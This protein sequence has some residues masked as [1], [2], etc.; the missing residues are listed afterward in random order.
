MLNYKL[1]LLCVLFITSLLG[2]TN[3][4]VSLQ[5]LWKHQFEFAG[6]YMAK[7]KGFYN[8]HKIDV[9]FKE[10]EVGT[11]ITKDVLNG[12]TTFGIGYPNIILEKSNGA[13]ITLLNA[14]FQS[15]PHALVTL[16]SSDIK[17]INDFKN[18]SIMVEND[19][20][21]TA[22]LL[23]MLY[24][25]KIKLEDM[26]TI[27][28][29][30]NIDDLVNHKVDIFSAYISNEVYKLD[31]NN[32]KYNIWNPKDYGFDF[33]NDLLFTSTKTVK[34][35]KELVDN[36]INASIRG[37]LYAFDNIDET[38]NL[39]FTKYNT[40]N[41]TKEALK[42]EAE[43]LKELAF[44][45]NSEFGSIDTNKI[46]RIYD[47]YNLMGLTKNK[48]DLEHFIYK[49]NNK[50]INL[51]DEEKLWIKR[52]TVKIGIS[53]W[54]PITYYNKENNKF[55][56]VGFDMV[57]S[58]VKKL[59]LNVQYVP[60]K[61]S[62]LLEN[63]KQNEIDVLPTTYYTKERATYG[64]FS[65][66][67]MDIKEQ[68]YVK[69][70]KN[71]NSFEDLKNGSIAI[72]KAYGAI[73]KIRKKYP[74]I[75]IVEVDTLKK[76]VDMVLTNQVDAIFNTQFGID[77][78]LNDNFIYDLKPIYQ[79]DF[80]PSPLH[81]FTNKT[82][83]I[84][85]N[86]LQKGL[87][88]LSFKEKNKIVSKWTNVQSSPKEIQNKQRDFLTKREKAYLENKKSITMCIDPNWMPFEKFDKGKHI[89]ISADY[90]KIFEQN[91]GK[92]IEVIQTKTWNQS[93]EFAKM[94]KCDLL[95]L[96]METPQRKK[97]MNFT[98]PYLSVPLVIAT[99]TQVTFINDI[100]VLEGKKIG[101]PKGYAFVEIFKDK[102]PF[103]NII[104]V[105]NLETGLEQVKRGELF[106]YIG[107]LASVGY[108]FQ[109]KFTGELKIA[110]KF[111]E[112]WELGIGVRNDDPILLNI[113][114]KVVQSVEQTQS[115]SILNN[116]LAIKY[117]QKV[118]Y[119]LLWQIFLG[120]GILLIFIIYRQ[121]ILRKANNDLQE[122]VNEK[123]KELL[124]LNKH[125]ELK[126][127]NAIEENA[128]K[129]RI[130]YTQSKMAAMGEMLANISHQWRQPLSVIS[131]VASGIKLKLEYNIFE[132]DEEIK[133]LDVLIDST[134]YLSAT[135][136]DFKNFLNPEKTNK[137]FNVKKII[138]K[139]I[140]MFGKNFTSHGIEIITNTEDLELIG[141]E[142]ELL[143]VII[144]IINNAKDAL[145]AQTL[146]KKIIFI[147]LYTQNNN[148]VL[149]IKDNGG[150][151]N[152]D[153]LPKIFDAYFTTKHKSIGTGIG[154]YMS[155]QIV[156]NSYDGTL[157]AANETFFY[158]DTQYTGAMFTI[159]IPIN[160]SN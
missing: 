109:T 88:S 76:S 95:S 128:K 56:G 69:K 44:L 11:D 110:G 149:S 150:G 62:V 49:T 59:N 87:D 134:S 97:F 61:W 28:P 47:V 79:T 19:A 136:D 114:E 22:P 129:D 143:Q 153:I 31:K 139:T 8:E 108:M 81:L 73:E 54:Y 68:L 9:E 82:N 65:R 86:I 23:S 14:I 106:G 155:Y 115:Q 46:H 38:V 29:S 123:T 159:T 6:F 145:E 71:I 113:M 7:E 157:V 93:L 17:T 80:K 116:W 42:F 12:T 103:L 25:N 10:Y 51:T 160:N 85:Q 48:L 94:R 21:K 83:T 41:K 158:D 37:W 63:F 92:K 1:F 52:N 140:Q 3:Q 137:Q 152:R 60:N 125:L 84:L 13:D 15:S 120:I 107:T 39:I 43:I 135:I 105:D 33:Y 75:K 151:I 57:N 16:Q 130:L 36:F 64:N 126:I 74:T 20:I 18:K 132:K 96:A 50:V 70:D 78:F 117:E 124:E 45:N 119:S 30:F 72:V 27:P 2:E 99:Q 122:K 91:L 100:K 131:T 98:T 142:N 144:N 147:D 4:K 35:N 26:K 90:F 112:S 34:N 127:K 156:T 53:P 101:I 24:A 102:Y 146:D 58:I 138:D 67:Y 66:P 32:I 77:S 111:D 133:N 5:L 141:H 121:I 89:G 55:G 40:Q 148:I 154:L 118:D 104:E